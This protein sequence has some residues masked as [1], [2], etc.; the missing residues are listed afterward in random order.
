MRKDPYFLFCCYGMLCFA[1]EGTAETIDPV[2]SPFPVSPQAWTA[3]CRPTTD[4]TSRSAA[5]SAPSSR[6][7]TAAS[8]PTSSRL[9]LV[10]S[11]LSFLQLKWPR[12]FLWLITEA[13]LNHVFCH[14]NWVRFFSKG[15]SPWN[16]LG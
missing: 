15:H 13:G 6:P 12:V 10:S 16:L 4:T 7:T 2:L 3:T 5:S 8:K 11:P 1:S 9:M 14:Q